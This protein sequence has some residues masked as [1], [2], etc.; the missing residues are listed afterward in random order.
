MSYKNLMTPEN[1]PKYL[2]DDIPT[3]SSPS[4]HAEGNVAVGCGC[5]LF[6]FNSFSLLKL[7]ED[8]LTNSP[9]AVQPC[10]FS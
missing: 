5:L 7:T 4:V 10:Y 8:G 3:L 1:V 6:C 2:L 9:F